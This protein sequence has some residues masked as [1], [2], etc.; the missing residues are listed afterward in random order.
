[1]APPL[2]LTLF[3]LLALASP[4]SADPG[5]D[6]NRDVRVALQ[7][8]LEDFSSS[9]AKSPGPKPG[10]ALSRYRNRVIE[11]AAD[12]TW[13]PRLRAGSIPW[14]SG[15]G[16]ERLGVT[17]YEP[18]EDRGT[19]LFV[20]GYMSHA[21]NFA[22]TFQFFTQRG[23][24]VVTLDLPGHGLSTGP[25]ADISSFTDYG[26]AV[27]TWLNWVDEQGWS[28]PRIL[29]AHSLGAAS[30]LEALRRPDTK[31]PDRVVFC[32]PLLRVDWHTVLGVGEKALGWW[33]KRLPTTFGWDG[34]LDGYSMPVHWFAALDRWL[35]GLKAQPPL[36]LPL[37]IYSGNQDTV[38]D[39][40]WNQKEYQR[41]VPGARY[42][43]VPGKGHLFLTERQDREA[44]HAQFAVDLGLPGL[45]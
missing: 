14:V 37:L 24:R 1:M 22:Y 43:L 12:P 34:Y 5:D 15:Y 36:T 9:I 16:P 6:P 35:E 25:R 7:A 13:E 19:L 32:A 26:S 41:L 31:R 20:H 11:V 40:G 23:F 29:L 45:R 44:F 39:E 33:W 21:A 2:R 10:S 30:C 42:V 18:Q 38:V 3:A 4:L 28:G 27:Q 8:E 17:V